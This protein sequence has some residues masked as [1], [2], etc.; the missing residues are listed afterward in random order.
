[1]VILADANLSSH[2]SVVNGAIDPAEWSIQKAIID[3]IS[4]NGADIS[5]HHV[6]GNIM[7]QVASKIVIH[8]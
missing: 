2:D 4:F 6:I 5:W 1:M 3:T 8:I 7:V